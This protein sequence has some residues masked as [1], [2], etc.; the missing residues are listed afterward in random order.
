MTENNP[1]NNSENEELAGDQD[2]GPASRPAGAAA[3]ENPGEEQDQDAG[4][5]STPDQH[6]E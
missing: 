3:Q 6:A 2:A 1:E 4:P 5:A